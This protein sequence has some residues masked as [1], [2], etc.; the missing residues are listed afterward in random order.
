MDK[1]IVKKDFFD[2]PIQE[3]FDEAW[4]TISAV[5]NLQITI[6][7]LE[8][9]KSNTLFDSVGKTKQMSPNQIKQW[10]KRLIPA[11]D[12]IIDYILAFHNLSSLLE[13]SGY[14]NKIN[15][16]GEV[17]KYGTEKTK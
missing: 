16:S 15:Q 11:I 4:N 14:L 1:H 8:T 13:L 5:A 12:E 3:L 6:D 9:I 10:K 7:S 2:K 17:I